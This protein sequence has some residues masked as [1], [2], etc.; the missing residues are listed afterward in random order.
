[1]I[2]SIQ[3]IEDDRRMCPV[4]IVEGQVYSPVGSR[5][6]PHFFLCLIIKLVRQICPY[7]GFPIAVPPFSVGLFYLVKT[8][9]RPI[10]NIVFALDRRSRGL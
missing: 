3:V 5:F 1:M 9:H 4:L 2:K 7:H 8:Y 6:I 10:P